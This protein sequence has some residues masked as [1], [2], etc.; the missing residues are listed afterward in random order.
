MGG[1]TFAKKSFVVLIK[2]SVSTIGWVALLIGSSR[3]VVKKATRNLLAKVSVLTRKNNKR[4]PE[5][6]DRTS[7]GIVISRLNSREKKIAP[8]LSLVFLGNF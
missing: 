7:H 8:T 4:M 1:R 6:V 5:F 3:N 2:T